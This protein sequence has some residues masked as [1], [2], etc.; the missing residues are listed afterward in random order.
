MKLF[1]SIC[2]SDIDK[3]LIRKG[4]NGKAYLTIEVCERQQ[5]GRYGDTHYIKQYCKS[6][7]RREGVNYFIGDLKPSLYD[8]Q[9]PARQPGLYGLQPVQT[10]DQHIDYLKAATGQA[11]QQPQPQQLQLPDDDDD[12]PF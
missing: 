10:L 3:N 1:G 7:E 8:Q 6:T 2:L 11:R 12:L 4:S 5:I 9:Q